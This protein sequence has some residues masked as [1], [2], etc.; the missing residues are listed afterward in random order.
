[1][2]FLKRLNAFF[3]TVLITVTPFTS[4]A[5]D[6]HDHGEAPA[7][8]SGQAR[9]RFTAISETFE[10]VGVLNGKQLTLYLDR[11]TD[12]SP[13]KDAKLELELGG[14]KVDVKPHG[15]GEF[16]AT[17]AQELKPGEITVS[18][19]VVAGQETDLLAGDLDIHEENHAGEV[20]QSQTWKVYSAWVVGGLLSLALLAWAL[21]R[22]RA[23]RI[24]RVGGAA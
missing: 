22:I 21:R 16:E 14:V 5:G 9:P 20:S 8:A 4:W 19:M 23:N 1:M 17:L 10:L 2:I 12:N 24:N 11:A 18:V 6:G 7:S 13:V 15:E 3:L